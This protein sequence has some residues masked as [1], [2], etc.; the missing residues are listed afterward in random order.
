MIKSDRPHNRIPVHCPTHKHYNGKRVLLV[1][2]GV[3]SSGVDGIYVWCR[4]CRETHF[5]SLVQ[6][7]A[8]LR[9]DDIMEEKEESTG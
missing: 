6:I 9:Q 1:E 2:I 8:S 7:V 4:K 3:N 5:L